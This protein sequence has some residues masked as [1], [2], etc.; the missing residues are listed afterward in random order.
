ME[1]VLTALQ[2]QAE[3]L[4]EIADILFSTPQET[5]RYFHRAPTYE[6]QWFKTNLA[7]A[8]RNRQ[9]F[10]RTLNHLKSQGLVVKKE[11]KGKPSWFPTK[12]GRKKIKKYRALRSD[13][14][15]SVSARFRQPAGAGLTIIVFDIPEKERRKREWLRMCLVAMGFQKLQKSV[16]MA[17]GKVQ[18]DFLH[19]LRE[20]DLLRYVHIF[21]A[22]KQGTL[23]SGGV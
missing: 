6:R 9:Q 19:A 2:Y 11:T 13:P 23:N 10:Y 3:G 1:L 21:V 14:F 8:Y 12:Y 20:R 4:L 5:R 18:E 15:S 7:E 22:T 17:K 16:W